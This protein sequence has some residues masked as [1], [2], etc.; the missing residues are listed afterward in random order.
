MHSGFPAH[1]TTFP[2]GRDHARVSRSVRPGSIE[3]QKT[4][5]ISGPNSE[6]LSPS[7][8]LQRSLESRLRHRM[9]VYGSLEYS[10]TWKR[11]DIEG[12]EPICA[13]R[14]S[15]RRTSGR[16]CTGWPTVS[17]RDHKGGYRGGRIRKGKI[18]TD[19]L[20]V[21]SQIAGWASPTAQDHS[22]GVNPPRPQDTGIPLSQQ[23]GMITSSSPASTEKRG[24]LNPDLCRWLMG[25]PTE[26][27][28]YGAMVTPSSRKSR[29]SSSRRSSRQGK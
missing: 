12:Q 18:S 13:L 6:G 29:Q 24:A 4:R 1:Q 7:A 10:L 28:L 17:T 20:D 16:D 5:A 19:T 23:V 3:E 22:R 11:W 27:G 2:S 26:W 9:G 25:Y 15:V 14:A 8:I 21:V